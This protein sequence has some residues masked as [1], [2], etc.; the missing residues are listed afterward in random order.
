VTRLG[1][2]AHYLGI[3]PWEVEL[4]TVSEFEALA[5]FIDEAN[6]DPDKK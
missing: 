6:K 1:L 5:D 3:R 2:F 4:L